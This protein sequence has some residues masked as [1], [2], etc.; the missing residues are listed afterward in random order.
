VIR[1]RLQT[2]DYSRIADDY[3]NLGNFYLDE[4]ADYNK[5]KECYLATVDYALKANNQEAVAAAH[6]N[7]EY[8][9]FKQHHY[10]DAAYYCIQALNNL[11]VTV[12]NNILINPS[13]K[14]LASVD[15]KELA[16]AVLANK[17]ELLLNVYKETGNKNYLATCL[18]TALLT[19]T[20]LTSMRHEQLSEQ[21]KLYWRN[22]TR[23]FFDRA[24]EACYLSNNASLAFYFMEKSRAVLLNDKLN[25]LGAAAY[26]PQ[27]KQ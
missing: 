2:L 16:F 7:L 14:Q 23:A 3:T 22:R 9:S 5:A 17:A 19:D 6:S 13:A 27:A 21:S 15:N 11:Q 12:N 4:L 25:E 8:C 24:M 18:Q 10:T 20:F 1:N 26:L